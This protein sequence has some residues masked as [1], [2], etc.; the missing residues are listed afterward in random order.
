MEALLVARE[1]EHQVTLESFL[2]QQ[3]VINNKECTVARERVVAN[4]TG[5]ESA[6][7]ESLFEGLCAV[8]CL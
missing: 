2:Q 1:T 5:W 8:E 4:G 7:P 6:L 3:G